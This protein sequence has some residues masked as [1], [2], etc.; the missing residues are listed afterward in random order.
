[1]APGSRPAPRL[2]GPDP[3]LFADDGRRPPGSRCR[4]AFPLSVTRIVDG[5]DGR[6]RHPGERRRIASSDDRIHDRD[7][8]RGHLRRGARR[9][10][11]PHDRGCA[12]SRSRVCD[13]PVGACGGDQSELSRRAVFRRARA[14]HWRRPWR[15]PDR[16]GGDA[17]VR[18]RPWRRRRDR[19]LNARVPGTSAQ[20]G[21][22]G[23]SPNSQTD[24]RRRSWYRGSR[25]ISTPSRSGV[26]KA[27]W[28][29]G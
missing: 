26:S 13:R 1:M 12:G 14:P 15:K 10:H 7:S 2:Q 11:S 17:L 25:K 9:A 21:T 8:R 19:R 5:A 18:G 29:G 28:A 22:G 20:K 4:R 23:G 27:I 24:G 3:L 16:V 6:C